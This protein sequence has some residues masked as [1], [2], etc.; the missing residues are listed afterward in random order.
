MSDK[1]DKGRTEIEEKLSLINKEI[2]TFQSNSKQDIQKQ[3]ESSNKVI[4]EVTSEL[5]KISYSITMMT[6][7]L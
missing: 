6:P 4:K 7:C 3:F 5:E 2:M 1:S